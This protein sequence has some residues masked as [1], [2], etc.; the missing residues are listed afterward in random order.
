[1]VLVFTLLHGRVNVASFRNAC[2]YRPRGLT[3]ILCGIVWCMNTMV[4][5]FCLESYT[6]TICIC[7]FIAL[8]IQATCAVPAQKNHSFS[9]D[10][11]Y[12]RFTHYNQ[13][14]L[15]LLHNLNK[16]KILLFIPCIPCKV[17]SCKHE[18]KL[19]CTVHSLRKLHSFTCLRSI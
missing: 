6:K 3:T 11:P 10:N 17:H 12:L 9:Y 5:G 16:E 15:R 19:N 18:F 8:H 2:I 14:K 1:M 13:E 4:L 7:S